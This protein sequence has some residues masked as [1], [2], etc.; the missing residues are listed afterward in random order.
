[1]NISNIGLI[2]PSI[3]IGKYLFPV[4]LNKKLTNVDLSERHLFTI[5]E[6]FF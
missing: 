2:E 3:W 4:K 6:K 1:M 5:K